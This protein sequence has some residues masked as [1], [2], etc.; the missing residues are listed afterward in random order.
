MKKLWL[1]SAG[2][3]SAFFTVFGAVMPLFYGVW[4]IAAAAMI[5]LGLLLFAFL[6]SEKRLPK[7]ARKVVGI[8]L[9]SVVGIIVVAGGINIVFGWSR[10]P[11]EPLPAVV[12]GCQIRG[13]RPSKMLAQRLDAAVEY[14]AVYTEVPV[15]VSGGTGE[16][17]RYSEA[18][19]MRDYL[20]EKGVD[21]DRILMEEHSADTYENLRN[22]FAVL[23]GHGGY[24]A[25]TIISNGF[26]Q[27]RAAVISA[28]LGKN[29]Y[30][31]SARTDADVAP[32][33]FIRELFAL[34]DYWVFSGR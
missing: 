8:G 33:Y 4:N 2:V 5:L 21:A 18:E 27:M 20:V 16:G 3:A 34:V 9:A 32:Y 7:T 23:D 28:A 10:A 29:A 19:V 15:V 11:R 31:V 24:S 1:I 25:V 26:H 6:L 17:Q 22:S 30:A 13:D 14:L 12:L